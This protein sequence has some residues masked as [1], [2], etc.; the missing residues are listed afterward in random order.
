MDGIVLVDKPLGWRSHDLV[1]YARKALKERVGHTGTLDPLATGLLILCVGEARKVAKFLMGYDKSY[2]GTII[3]GMKTDTMD[4]EG[5]IVERGS[6]PD[7]SEEDIKKLEE[8]LVGDMEQRPPTISAVRV[9]GRRLYDLARSGI[10]VEP[11]LR[12]IRVYEFKVRGV[13]KERIDF[14]IRCSSGTYVREIAERVGSLLGT[15]SCLGRLRRTEVGPF[16]VLDAIKPEDIRD[17][18]RAFRPLDEILEDIQR[19]EVE[20]SEVMRRIRN[21]AEVPFEGADGLVRIFHG[22][23]LEA[24][25]VCRGGVLRADR[26]F[27]RGL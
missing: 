1:A 10:V 16:S 8:V 5:R 22:G 24:L 12:R 15:V 19:V 26:V 20:D 25:G 23:R 6:I 2:E 9:K 11:P 18:G 17:P 14:T 27:N 4:L 3:I 13:D 7:L 21:G